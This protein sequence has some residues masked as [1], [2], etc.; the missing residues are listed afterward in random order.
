[1][2]LNNHLRK[3]AIHCELQLCLSEQ[4]CTYLSKTTL[5]SDSS[6][7]AIIWPGYQA[8]IVDEK[9]LPCPTED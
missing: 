4:E 9:S 2:Y 1:M 6:E 3:K 8:D 7:V 5:A